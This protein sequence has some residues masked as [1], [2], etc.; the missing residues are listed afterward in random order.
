MDRS[1]AGATRG[2]LPPPSS[3]HRSALD[4]IATESVSSEASSRRTTSAT[5]SAAARAATPG[6]SRPQGTSTMGRPCHRAFIT[7][8][9][10]AWLTSRTPRSKTAE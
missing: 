7:D 3:L 10:P 2:G 5:P 6:W 1:P 8:P 4:S 9:C